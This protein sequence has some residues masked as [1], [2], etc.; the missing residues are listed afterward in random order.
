MA[1]EGADRVAGLRV[2]VAVEGAD[3]VV[4]ADGRTS[5]PPELDRVTGVAG[6]RFTRLGWLG[7]AVV[8]GAGLV[9]AGCVTA[10]FACPAVAGAGA[11]C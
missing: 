10:R 3:R 6:T 4:G 11:A 2:G 8:T 5:P 1:A 9:R 7:P